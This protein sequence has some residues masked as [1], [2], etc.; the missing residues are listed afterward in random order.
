LLEAVCRYDADGNLVERTH[1]G[2]QVFLVS[3][4]ESKKICK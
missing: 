1:D 3:V 4:S 2:K